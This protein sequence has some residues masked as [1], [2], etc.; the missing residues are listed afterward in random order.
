MTTL[1]DYLEWRG[2]LTFEQSP[3]NAVDNLIL[4]CLGYVV[5]D[6]LVSGFDC[7]YT[8]SVAEA[9]ALFA[10]LPESVK[11]LRSEKDEQVLMMMAQ[12]ER[13]GNLELLYHVDQTD[14]QIEKQFAAITIDLGN[15]SYYVA[16]RGTDHTVVGWKEDFNMTFCNAVPA[17]LE[18]VRYLQKVA[19]KTEGS[20]YVGG[21]SKGGN[22]AIYAAAHVPAD[23][24]KRIVTVYNNDGPGFLES[25]I[26]SE[27][28][29]AI[30]GRIKTYIPQ[31]SLFGLMLEH[32]EPYTVIES[33][34]KFVMQHDP[35]TWTVKGP[36]F[37]YLEEVTAS[38]RF[39]DMT[40]HNWLADITPEQRE[41]FVDAI[42]DAI[43]TEDVVKV[44]DLARAWLT[45]AGDM[46]KNLWDMDEETAEMIRS[47]LKQLLHNIGRTAYMMI[48]EEQETIHQHMLGS[49]EH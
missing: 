35:Y 31:T 8:T 46:L 17:Q 23:V 6:E 9:A 47:I 25:V 49:R 10:Q 40:L 30:C 26:S 32:A 1:F 34:G 5:L 48:K 41:K 4:S 22:L 20:L 39:M 45:N 16:Y 29:Q 24:Q 28:Y 36:D 42:Y 44:Q 33:S 27:G 11:N 19:E 7:C 37:I 14:R 21:H 15:G 2:D 3:F 13:F 12:T 38:G 18:A 43:A